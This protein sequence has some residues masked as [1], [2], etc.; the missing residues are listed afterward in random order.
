MFGVGYQE[1]FV[2]LVIA[3]VVFGPQRLPE[4]AGQA[5]R[6]IREFRK[7]TAGLT[8]EFEKTMAEVDDIRETVRREMKSMMDEVDDVTEGVKRDLGAPSNGKPAAKSVAAR[9]GS[10]TGANKDK[11]G[12]P[13][14]GRKPA[15]LVAATKADP[16]SDVSAL[17]DDLLTGP[18]SRRIVAN[19]KAA[20]AVSAAKPVVVEFEDDAA[21][22][23]RK[24]R[25]AAA[26]SKRV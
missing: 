4:L 21:V 25:A 23:V 15:A 22:R 6:W 13:G 12:R 9:T 14:A 18:T 5:G 2:I 10:G 16:L 7:M 11:P 19:G 8:G 24:R 3:L 26:Y 17:D 20:A 1:M